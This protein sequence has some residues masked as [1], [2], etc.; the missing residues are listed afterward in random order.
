MESLK[1]KMEISVKENLNHIVIIEMEVEQFYI[2]MEIFIM[3][4]GKIIKKMEK[5]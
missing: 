5:E 3:E 2:K 1:L 4:N